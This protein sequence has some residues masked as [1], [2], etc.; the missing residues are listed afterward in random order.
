MLPLPLAA[1]SRHFE[2]TVL[3]SGAC[4]SLGALVSGL[5]RRSFVSLTALFVL[6]GFVLG[7]GGSACCTSTPARIRHRSGQVALIVILFRDGLEVEGEML[8]TH[9]HLPLRKLVLAMPLTAVIV[10][11]AAQLARRPGL[12]RV[13]SCSGRCSPPPTRCCPRAWSPTRACRG[14]SATP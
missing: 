11:L 7:H 3:C 10:A 1:V 14:S 5:A 8:Q 4:S 2:T 12:D 9:W 13:P 6:A